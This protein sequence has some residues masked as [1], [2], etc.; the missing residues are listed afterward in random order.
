VF[1]PIGENFHKARGAWDYVTCDGVP[2]W[3]DLQPST[4]QQAADALKVLEGTK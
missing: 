1:E 3:R 2:V 4:K